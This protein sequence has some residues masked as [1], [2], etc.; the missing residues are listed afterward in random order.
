MS[1]KDVAELDALDQRRVAATLANDFPAL[2]EIY[3][4][5]LVYTH[6]NARKDTRAV[7]L[8]DMRAGHAKY[9]KFELDGIETVIA[10]DT[11]IR[12]GKM[13]GEVLARG[14]HVKLNSAFTQV[15]VRRASGWKMIAWQATPVPGA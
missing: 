11:A 3:D 9:V 7:Y 8:G 2:E 15:W 10:G 5:A 6:S 14:N 4:D 12:T 1:T 13:L